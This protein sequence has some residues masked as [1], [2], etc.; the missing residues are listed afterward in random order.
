M[1]AATRV[2]RQDTTGPSAA[3]AQRPID[4]PA[5][6]RPHLFVVV[7]TEEEFDWN[8]P[9][10][11]TSTSVTA[12]RHIERAQRIFDRFGIRP[13]Y[14]VDYPVAS[15]PDGYLPLLEVYRSGRCDIGAHPHPWVNP[16]DDEAVCGRHTFM[17]NLPE[18]LQRA[19]LERLC[20]Q[21]GTIFGKSPTTFKAGRYGIGATTIAVLEQLGFTVDTSVCPRF[22]FSDEDGPSF[23]ELDSRPFFLAPH[24]LEVPCTVDYTGWAGPLRPVL[25]RTAA[26]KSLTS[27]R[28][29]GVLARM[30]AVNRVMLSPEGNSVA[31]MRSLTDALID[32]G[33]RTFTFSFHSPSLD[34]GHTPYVRTQA[35][36]AQFLDDIERFC[37]FFIAERGGV[38]STHADF[39]AAVSERGV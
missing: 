9:P 28:G 17:C 27:L 37:E 24:L 19:K 26:H 15:Q 30:G 29:V 22:D 11:R 12:M 34:V 13:L 10:R 5:S 16:P 33:L 20:T 31:D 6:T 21:I 35:D 4:L 32:H 14:V 3:R 38:A 18:S 39:R 36:L 25:H 23:A 7:D 1:S 2:T 8:A